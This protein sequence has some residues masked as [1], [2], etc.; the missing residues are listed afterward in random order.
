MVL[1]VART[2]R[3][4]NCESKESARRCCG[5]TN[6]RPSR[7][8][9]NAKC[10]EASSGFVK[11]AY[12]SAPPEELQQ[13]GYQQATHIDDIPRYDTRT[14]AFL[15]PL[16][17]IFH[18]LNLNFGRFLVQAFVI[19]ES[20]LI[21]CIS[22]PGGY[23]S[24]FTAKACSSVSYAAHNEQEVQKC[25]DFSG[26]NV[27]T[28]LTYTHS[29]AEDLPVCQCFVCHE[30]PRPL[31]RR[32]R[33]VSRHGRSS[34]SPPSATPA[35]STHNHAA[36]AT[37]PGTGGCQTHHTT[38][39]LIDKKSQP[40]RSPSFQATE[41]VTARH[42]HLVQKFNVVPSLPLRDPGE[43]VGSWYLGGTREKKNR[44][45]RHQCAHTLDFTLWSP[46]KSRDETDRLRMLGYPSI[47]C[48]LHCILY[49]LHMSRRGKKRSKVNRRQILG[50][51][52]GR[53]LTPKSDKRLVSYSRHPALLSR[54]SRA[55]QHQA[56]ACVPRHHTCSD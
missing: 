51:E 47:L 17:H 44:N 33:L 45:H 23:L 16:S 43:V 2:C 56:Q 32:R 6:L 29:R 41:R 30:T 12:G 5:L 14:I 37:F 20:Q 50:R 24:T 18:S 53:G 8:G 25:E 39:Q 49:A 48:T 35:P 55:A 52:G 22:I 1:Q 27:A 10:R 31:A 15:N 36:V 4:S 34:N 28:T 38:Q 13:C 19:T 40:R 11:K 7:P 42:L 3:K 54:Y 9:T 46:G 26:Q 21:Q